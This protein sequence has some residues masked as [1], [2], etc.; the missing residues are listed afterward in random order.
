[1]KV[2]PT[3]NMA[4]TAPCF[5][6]T[7]TSESIWHWT[8]QN[9]R[10]PPRKL[11]SELYAGGLYQ[12][13]SEMFDSD[14][15][16]RVFPFQMILGEKLEYRNSCFNVPLNMLS[17]PCPF[18]TADFLTKGCVGRASAFGLG[19]LSVSRYGARY[20]DYPF[21]RSSIGASGSDF[22]VPGNPGW[23]CS[24]L[25]DDASGI[26]IFLHWKFRST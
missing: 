6:Q 7:S 2:W 14:S 21:L 17:W 10:K 4:A 26:Y 20:S 13:D 8:T 11:V 15:Q 5:L 23:L 12:P 24:K 22:F 25:Q 16:L 1:M 3:I 9:Q 19:D 18:L